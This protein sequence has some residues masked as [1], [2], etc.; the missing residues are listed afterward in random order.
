MRVDQEG[1][2]A[3]G[4]EGGVGGGPG[5]TFFF[6]QDPGFTLTWLNWAA[7]VGNPLQEGRICSCCSCQFGLLGSSV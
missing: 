4:P 7:E 6:L 1:A 3:R 2:G 5:F